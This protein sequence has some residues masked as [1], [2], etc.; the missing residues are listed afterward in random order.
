M[1]YDMAGGPP[2]P[3]SLLESVC[4][5]MA[6]KRRESEFFR[7][8]LLIEAILAPHT[9]DS[10]N[11]N[12]ALDAYREAMFPFLET[13]R[14][15]EAIQTKKLLHHWVGKKAFRIRPIWRAHESKGVVSRLRRGAERV[16]KIEESRRLIRHRRI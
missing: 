5:L 15:R 4:T 14:K 1:L 8:K 9:E 16:R 13:E 7:T 6:K 10:G 2:E 12:K 3:G 11:L